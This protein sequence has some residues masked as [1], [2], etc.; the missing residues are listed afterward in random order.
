MKNT[1][2]T[3]ATILS[4]S[5]LLFNKNGYAETSIMDIASQADKAKGSIYY[6]FDKKETILN[7]LFKVE[8][9]IFKNHIKELLQIDLPFVEKF[10]YYLC[11]RMKHFYQNFCITNN[12]FNLYTKTNQNILKIQRE[13]HNWETHQLLLFLMKNQSQ[14]HSNYPITRCVNILHFLIQSIEVNNLQEKKNNNYELDIKH[15]MHIIVNGIINP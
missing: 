10:E 2:N 13:F 7:E 14:I 5:K 15:S 4:A 9:L 6:Y 1:P 3:R 11:E 8:T 12:I